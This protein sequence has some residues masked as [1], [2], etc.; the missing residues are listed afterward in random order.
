MDHVNFKLTKYF[1][2]R[3]VP[4]IQ[5]PWLP[6]P[7]LATKLTLM[8]PE[9]ISWTGDHSSY[10]ICSVSY[11]LY[12]SRNKIGSRCHSN[13]FYCI[14]LNSLVIYQTFQRLTL[15]R[16]SVHAYNILEQQRMN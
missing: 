7:L 3:Y 11:V 15:T 14:S 13:L 4:Q 2:D 8:D 16:F 6:H 9:H 12:L 10:N 5:T 1:G